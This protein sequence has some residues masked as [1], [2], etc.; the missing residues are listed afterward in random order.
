MSA[1]ENDPFAKGQ[2]IDRYEIRDH[3]GQ[4]GM[5]AVYRAV[6]TRLGRTVALKTVVAHR[7]GD[8]LTEEV[9]QRFMREALAASRVDHRNVV[10]VLDFGFSEDGTP[11]MVMEFLRG[12]SLSAVLKDTAAPLQV[13]YVAD[14]MLSVCAALRACHHVGIIHRDLKPANIFLCDTD[15]GWDVK[16]LDFGISKAAMIDDLTQDG[17]IVGTPQ[18][19]SPEQVGGLVGPESDQYAIGVLLYACLTQQLPY[20]DYQNQRLLRAVQ[21]GTFEPPRKHR[22]DLPEGL[23][24]I[25]LRA[26]HV[27]AKDRFESIHALG[28]ALWE[29]ASPRGQTQ[30]KNF[31]FHTPA[32]GPVARASTDGAPALKAMAEA[33]AAAAALAA[34]P[35]PAAIAPTAS[36]EK[37][38]SVTTAPLRPAPLVTEGLGP[39]KTADA[40]AR[41]DVSLSDI[42]GESALSDIRD[43]ISRKHT[44]RVARL[45][46]ALVLAGAAALVAFAIR[47]ARTPTSAPQQQSVAPSAATVAA[48]S[49]HRVLAPAPPAAPP[50]PSVASPP[51]EPPSRTAPPPAP[52]PEPARPIARRTPTKAPKTPP[53]PRPKQHATRSD[54]RP[55]IDRQGI[56]IPTD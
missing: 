14:V 5:G 36:L 2:R 12:K 10:Q 1:G 29:F 54:P 41:A 43:T 47:S 15:T 28:Q 19:L 6:D 3:I 34:K 51:A 44:R 17:Q 24:A 8:K 11:Y 46:R 22:P 20:G 18:Y 52:A 50:P 48:P 37:V 27:S 45:R 32:A 56:G 16:V 30:W 33:A 49:V 35:K 7:R 23:E 40:G 9:R 4:G 38:A 26:M 55:T 53:A 13:D 42:A 21:E 31:Y 25:I 39:T